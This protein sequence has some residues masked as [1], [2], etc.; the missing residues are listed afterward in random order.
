MPA[1]VALAAGRDD[2]SSEQKHVKGPH[3]QKPSS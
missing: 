3:C 1:E 2:I